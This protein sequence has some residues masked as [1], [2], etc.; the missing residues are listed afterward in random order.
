[1]KNKYKKFNKDV[2]QELLQQYLGTYECEL[3][4]SLDD[5]LFDIGLPNSAFPAEQYAALGELV[6]YQ[7]QLS[8][9]MCSVEAQLKRKERDKLVANAEIL[10]ELIDDGYV[11]NERERSQLLYKS[12][13]IVD[14][15][16]ELDELETVRDYIKSKHFMLVHIMKLY[17]K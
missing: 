2:L 14:A 1:M 12:P 3:L 17:G 9:V 5:Y 7:M 16:Q 4:E 15:K 13:S 10:E 8:S 11:K 6:K